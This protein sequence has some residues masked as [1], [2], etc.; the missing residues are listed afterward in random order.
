MDFRKIQHFVHVAELGSLSRAAE[1]LNIVQ[2]ALSQSIKRLEEELDTLLF[3]RSRRGMELTETGHI[4]L[5]HA[6]GI[7]N[8]YN[9]AKESLLTTAESPRGVVSVAMTASASEVLTVPLSKKLIQSFPDINLNIESGLAGNIQQGFEAGKYDLVLSHLVQPSASIRIE[10]LIQE[11]LFLT[12]PFDEDNLGEDIQF[13][14]LDN[15]QLTIPQEHHG[16]APEIARYAK[17]KNMKILSAQVAGALHPTLQLI[18]AGLGNSVLPWSAI[19]ERVAQNRLSA[20]KVINPSLHHTVNMAYPAH[21]PLTPAAIAVMGLIRETAQLVHSKG[22]WSGVLLVS[23]KHLMP[24][25]RS[26]S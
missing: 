16:V 26:S 18:E 20:R 14:E 21:R 22:K 19:N 12:L 2:P 7:L 10:P 1:R 9:R 3:T 4:F 5:K 23:R 15:M 17:E 6:Y 11:D 25:M 24:Q 8:Q 13:K